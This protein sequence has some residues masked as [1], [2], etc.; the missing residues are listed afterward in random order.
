MYHCIIQGPSDYNKN[1]KDLSTSAAQETCRSAIFCDLCAN[2]FNI[3]QIKFVSNF[4]ADPISLV[5]I[6]RGN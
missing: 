4:R 6:D 5:S 2:N 1:A 3:F